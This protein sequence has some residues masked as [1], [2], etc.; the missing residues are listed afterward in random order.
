MRFPAMPALAL[1]AT[2]ALAPALPAQER[3]GV[4]DPAAPQA[5]RHRQ[6]VEDLARLRAEQSRAE[7]ARRKLDTELDLV[8]ADRRKLAESLVSTAATVRTLE[9]R[10]AGL[11]SRLA[12]IAAREQAIRASLAERHAVISDV[13]AALQRIGRQPPP[14]LLV[15]PDDALKQLRGAMTFGALVPDLRRE[16]ERLVADLTELASLREGAVQDRADLDAALGD[17]ET[18]RMRLG[19]LIEERQRRQADIE[20][21]ARAERDRA[22]QLARRAD[23]VRDLVNRLEQEIASARKAAEAARKA[24]AEAAAR[25]ALEEQARAARPAEP[26]DRSQMAAFMA[27][28]ARMAPAQPF[29]KTRGTLSLPV[30]GVRLKR[31]GQSDGMGGVER[32]LSV[33]TRA[34]AEVV[35]PADGWVVYAGPFR[36]YGH[37]LILNA[38]GG[39]HILLAGMERISVDPGQ[40]VVAGEPVAQ[41]GSGTVALAGAVSSAAP[42]AGQPVLYI[43]FRKDGSPIDPT[44]WWATNEQEKVR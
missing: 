29:I 21:A 38:G 14:A 36:S 37:V 27:N 28:P 32:G 40:F 30:S 2:F 11:E 25:A 35:S 26:M 6:S 43:E 44:P 7:E 34:R 15:H 9:T 4:P 33:A 8:R 3:D 17:I 22:V 10:I 42:G 12:D 39:Y 24:E 18:D 41:M 5:E 16:A 1:A 13:L 20:G 31:F 19:A 23:S